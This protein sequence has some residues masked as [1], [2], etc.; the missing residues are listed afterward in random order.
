MTKRV[1]LAIALCALVAAGLIA[2]VVTQPDS[3]PV[4]MEHV[5]NVEGGRVPGLVVVDDTYD[6]WGVAEVSRLEAT[7]EDNVIAL[8][9]E[10][11]DCSRLGAVGYRV[12]E[13]SRQVQVTIVAGETGNCFATVDPHPAI[14][15]LASPLGERTLVAVKP[16]YDYR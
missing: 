1:A 13:T 9:F 11:K 7:A 4:T 12:T 8:V 3:A 5:A 16:N 15:R 2:F 10:T 14:L 6:R